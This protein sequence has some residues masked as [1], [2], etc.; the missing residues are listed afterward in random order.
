MYSNIYLG[1]VIGCL[2]VFLFA[3]HLYKVKE[4][5]IQWNFK[6]KLDEIQAQEFFDIR[7][8]CILISL[9]PLINTIFL[10]KVIFNSRI[11]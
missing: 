9:L 7:W 6:E 3:K 11:K 5:K 8:I 2:L 4:G 1:S 10:L